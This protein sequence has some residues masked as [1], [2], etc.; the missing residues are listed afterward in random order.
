M[1]RNMLLSIKN[2]PFEFLNKINKITIPD[3][4]K[5][6]KQSTEI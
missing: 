5:T 1:E 3:K 4:K 6:K 2:A